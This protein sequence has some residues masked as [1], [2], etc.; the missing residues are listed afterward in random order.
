VIL[1]AHHHVS[2]NWVISCPFWQCIVV[3]PK[4]WWI[5]KLQ[6]VW[7]LDQSF[8]YIIGHF[9][10]RTIKFH[11][12]WQLREQGPSFQLKMNMLMIKG[13]LVWDWKQLINSHMRAEPNVRKLAWLFRIVFVDIDQIEFSC[14]RVLIHEVELIPFVVIYDVIFVLYNLFVVLNILCLL[15]ISPSHTDFVIVVDPYF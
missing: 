8:P 11:E 6:V 13:V 15:N 4:S 14:P 7:D 5:A 9:E 2:D 12:S 10:H 1:H 3:R